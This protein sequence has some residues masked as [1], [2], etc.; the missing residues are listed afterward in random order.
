MIIS[1][2]P[3]R[4]SLFGG[5]TDHEGYFKYNNGIVI[6]GAI[7][8][9]IY[10]NLRILPH[11]FDHKYRISWSKIENVKNVNDIQHPTVREV[12]KY[13]KV[14]KG[15]EVHYDG[16]LPGNSGTG[17]S[18]S[19]AVG[20]IKTILQLNKKKIKDEKIFKLA[21]EIEKNKLNESTGI[22]DHV[23]ATLGGFK[24]IKF[25]HDR[26]NFKDIK[27]D[28][29]KLVKLEDN[30][31]LIYTRKKR[32]ANLI[33]QNKFKNFKQKKPILD[34][35][36]NIAL[37]AK[38]ILENDKNLNL[39]EIGKLLDESWKLKKLLS[40]KVTLNIVDELYEESKKLGARGGKLIG[41][42]GGGFLLINAS[43]NV[44]KKIIKKF[45]KLTC[46]KFKFHNKG[47]EIIEHE[48]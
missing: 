9:F 48:I 3:Y 25:S 13:F 15:L 36:K 14:K 26:I 21:Y 11:F 10:I 22:Q 43:Q 32:I 30:L 40:P 16:D 41:A 19:F 27:I 42:G 29:K 35:V 45:K 20:I 8:K 12:L 1:K 2:T 24:C 17:S 23:F 4:I 37:E 39:D 7:N 18:A 44:Q 47:S 31:L 33:E 5:G 34:D 6:G 38:K 28:K 46:I